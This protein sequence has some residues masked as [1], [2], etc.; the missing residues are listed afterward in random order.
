MPYEVLAQ[1]P[2]L[3]SFALRRGAVV[4]RAGTIA[5]ARPLPA[6]RSL[7]LGHGDLRS[8]PAG[9]F[10]YA[11]ALSQLML[12][13]NE[14][15][16]IDEDALAGLSELLSLS[17]NWNRLS[18]LPRALLRPCPRLEHVNLNDNRLTSLPDD[19]FRGLVHLR[20]VGISDNNAQLYLSDHQFSNLPALETVVLRGASI[21]SLPEHLLQNSTGLEHLDL[22][23]NNL[24]SVPADMF[25]GLLKLRVLNLSHNKLVYIHEKL[26]WNL[27]KLDTLDLK[28]NAL[29]GLP[30]GVFAGLKGLKVLKLGGNHID[31]LDK[32][33]FNALSELTEL[34]LSGNRI[35][36]LHPET[37][38]PITKLK[39]LSLA[40]NNMSFSR[41]SEE[42]YKCDSPL[43]ALKQLTTLDLSHNRVALMCSDWHALWN[44]KTLDLSYNAFTELTGDDVMFRSDRLV[45]DLSHNNVTHIEEPIGYLVNPR[46]RVTFRLNHNLFNCDCNMLPYVDARR[47]DLFAVDV[48]LKNAVCSR[49]AAL[50]DV[51]LADLT[52]DQ[53]VCDG[54]DC[55]R[56]CTCLDRPFM[57]WME[58]DC[59]ALPPSLPQQSGDIHLR[60]RQPSD[61]THLPANVTYVDLSAAHLTTAPAVSRAVEI[62]LTN[63]RLTRVPIELL[64]RNCVLHLATNPI[65]CSCA[66]RDEL[67]FLK[68]KH[69]LVK[70]YRNITCGTNV[71]LSGVDTEALCAARDATVIGFSVAGVGVLVAVLTGIAYRYST[72]IRLVLIKFGLWW[73]KP[74]KDD[75]EYDAFVSFSHKDE[76]YVV[77]TLVPNLKSGRNPL[78]LCLHYEDWVVGEFIPTQIAR[79]VEKSR[80][81]IIV[82]SEHFLNSDWAQMEF[83]AAHGRERL[84]ILMLDDL[85]SDKHLDPDL[86]AYM[87]MNTYIKASDP[88]VYDRLK[89]SVRYTNTRF[90]KK[91][92]NA[93]KVAGPDVH[94]N[95]D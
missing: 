45:V 48:K 94:L 47:R 81:T 88:L 7:E 38:S 18:S 63:N 58:I 29:E 43:R 11:P 2:S 61:L 6:L 21:Q 92:K 87:N 85:P 25:R 23:A 59:P 16:D 91:H 79:S 86:K 83:R 1:L 19:L 39:I 30:E 73:G 50:H 22:S 3:G 17:L 90:G 70:D 68:L 75:Y 42:K 13:A 65:D 31:A 35:Q 28:G 5:G 36:L 8:V 14:I 32:S 41:L 40:N 34:D 4:L 62:D 56:N 64:K 72:E 54:P 49:P 53:L 27:D 82:L 57:S 93:D 37:F 33:V 95:A 69:H 15:E 77:D 24:T 55:P 9:A 74:I 26:F 12:W 76:V 51:P 10:S 78:K 52:P 46:P 20:Y 67:E 71:S 60:L 89:D 84:I 44:L 80:R 66:N